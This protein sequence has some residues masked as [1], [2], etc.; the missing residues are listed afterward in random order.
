MTHT[1]LED[2]QRLVEDRTGFGAYVYTP[3]EQ[4]AE[5]WR[6][7][8]GGL[9]SALPHETVT[10]ATVPVELRG[11]GPVG[12]LFRQ[13]GTPNYETRRVVRLC[14]QHGLRLLIW[15][16]PDDLFATENRDKHALGRLGFYG[17][18]GRNGGRRLEYLR[19]FDVE[20]MNRCPLRD[21]ATFRGEKLTD[22]H[23]RLLKAECPEIGADNIYDGSAWFAAHGGN[24]RIYYPAFMSLFLRHAVLFETFVL[25]ADGERQ[26]TRDVFLPVFHHLYQATGLK[27][28]V[29][30]SERE[31]WE[32]DD[33]WHLY[34]E[35]LRLQLGPYRVRDQVAV[36][37]GL[38]WETPADR[39]SLPSARK[40]SARTAAPGR[41]LPLVAGGVEG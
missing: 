12:I 32:G 4:A 40:T 33:F 14:A 18:L 41:L 19:V 37:T 20:A 5:S 36:E 34:P 2:I 24:A 10:G 13:I 11:G 7:R 9:F 15:E 30:P 39:E 26:F 22:F 38:N 27:P 29:V 31:D 6:R 17:G 21:I 3:I 25:Q 28:L 16:Y 23:H 35:P 1:K 8:H